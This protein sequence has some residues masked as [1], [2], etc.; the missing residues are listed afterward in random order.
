MRLRSFRKSKF[1]LVLVLICF[2]FIA[3]LAFSSGVARPSVVKAYGNCQYPNDY[4]G[5]FNGQSFGANGGGDYAFGCGLNNQAN[6][7]GPTVPINYTDVTADI[8]NWAQ[9]KELGPNGPLYANTSGVFDG[10]AVCN[11]FNQ[12]ETAAFYDTQYQTTA[13]FIVLTM[14]EDPAYC[15][16]PGNPLCGNPY[17][18]GTSP[19]VGASTALQWQKAENI[20][21]NGGSRYWSSSLLIGPSTDDCTSNGTAGIRNSLYQPPQSQPPP[22]GND[23]ARFCDTSG[24]LFNT[25]AVGFTDPTSKEIYEIRIQCGN[26]IGQLP[27]LTPILSP[28]FTCT[29]S[30]ASPQLVNVSFQV[31]MVIKSSNG[32]S[33]SGTAT[34]HDATGG[35]SR[36]NN[37]VNAP[38]T[39]YWSQAIVGVV[40]ASDTIS[41]LFSWTDPTNGSPASTPCSTTISVKNPTQTVSCTMTVSS[42]IV[43]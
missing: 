4:C 34:A 1:G 28:A 41:G 27:A 22:T 39:V 26:P 2:L 13:E 37:N 20:L 5:Y 7:N 25:Y 30:A 43:Y 33:V 29:I 17:P 9:G 6:P 35:F 38:G 18:A 42:E 3:T 14:T 12:V 21:T 24:Q 8:T 31:T 10:V 32:F 15:V 19:S 16:T 11:D 23:I 40:D 36:T